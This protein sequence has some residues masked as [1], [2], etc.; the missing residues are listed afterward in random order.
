MLTMLDYI[1]QQPDIL[2][3]ITGERAR[4][5]VRQAADRFAGGRDRR[6]AKLIL[7]GSGTSYNAAVAASRHIKMPTEVHYPYDFTEY[8]SLEGY[9]EHCLFVFISQGGK[10]L[11][12]YHALEKVRQWPG[13]KFA[14]LALVAEEDTPLGRLADGQLLFGC[15]RE[16]VIYRTKGFTSSLLTLITL[17]EYL[18]GNPD[19][20]ASR[21]FA[22]DCAGLAS[23]I[24][25]SVGFFTGQLPALHDLGSL[26]FIGSG[27]NAVIALEGSLKAIETIRR[28]SMY[29]DL[30]EFIHGPQNAVNDHTAL[31]II[32][33]QED[34]AGKAR[35][36]FVALRRL[37]KRAWLIAARPP[38]EFADYSLL[39][40]ATAIDALAAIIPLQVLCYL[41]AGDIGVDLT[42]RGFPELSGIIA[43]AL[44]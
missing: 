8:V 22:A 38:R 29:F 5:T 16:E 15:G 42:Q 26:M 35:D 28:P 6:R 39:R 30:E 18:S 13:Q 12:T 24:D 27:P 41:T 20:G 10:S 17:G 21:A 32:E 4:N 9:D 25:Q 31:I 33:N 37:G 3:E 14:T 19:E 34:K 11:S 44:P 43:K 40:P 2:G 1:K 7:I 23:W 36:L